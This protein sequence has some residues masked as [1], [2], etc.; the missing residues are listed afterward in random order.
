MPE[1]LEQTECSDRLAG[2][3]GQQRANAHHPIDPKHTIES[4]TLKGTAERV[5]HNLKEAC[6]F[7]AGTCRLLP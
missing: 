1:I 6:V 3:D 5:G 7:G 2:I 4:C